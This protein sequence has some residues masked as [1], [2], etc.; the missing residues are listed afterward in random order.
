VTRHLARLLDAPAVLSTFSRLVIDPN[1]ADDDPTQI[2]RLYDGTIIPANRHL[3]EEEAVFRRKTYH[4]PYH[5]QIAR[6]VE[7]DPQAPYIAVHSFGPK[8]NGRAPRPWHI[9]FLHSGDRR[10]SDPVIRILSEDPQLC[11]G[12]NQPYSGHLPGDSVYRHALLNGRPNLLI[13]LRHDLIRTEEQQ[14]AWAERLAPVLRAAASE[15]KLCSDRSEG[16][17]QWM[18]RPA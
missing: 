4:H 13:E 16:Q 12:D 17:D 8:L 15:A 5:E 9:G 7:K 1:R 2:M 6:I 11:V 18:T 14:E 10:L 3:T